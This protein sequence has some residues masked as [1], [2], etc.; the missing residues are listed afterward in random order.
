MRGFGENPECPGSAARGTLGQLAA[1]GSG[2]PAEGTIP[3]S[4]GRLRVDDVPLAGSQ[5]ET[6][7]QYAELLAEFE[8]FREYLPDALLE[9]ELPSM[10]VTFMNSIAKSL[11]GYTVDDILAG[12]YGWQLLEPESLQRAIALADLSLDRQ[13]RQGRPYERRPGQYLDRYTVIRKDGTP[14]AVEAQ[15]AFIVDGRGVPAGARFLFRDISD[16]LARDQER[17]RLAAIVESA[18][19]AIVSR[20]LEGRILSWNRGAERLYG[21][22][23]AEMV[24]QTA[25]VLAPPGAEGE[26]REFA[27]RVRRGESVHVTTRRRRRDGTVFDVEL[28]LFPVRDEQGRVTAMAGIARD[29]SERLRMTQELERTNR[30]LAALTRAQRDFI[31]G[32]DPERVF[33]ALLELLVELTGSE[34]GFIGEVEQGPGGEPQ[35]VPR[36]FVHPPTGEFEAFR[37]AAMPGEGRFANLATL[38]G[39]T[40]RTGEPVIAN[41][42]AADPRAGGIP[43]GHPELRS[44]LGIPIESRG[45]LV[46]LVGLANR[47]GGY[48]EELVAFVQP[49]LTTCA[50]VIE[51]LRAEQRRAEAERQLALALDGS[52][53]TLWDWDIPARRLRVVAGDAG[54]L[55]P[56]DT[57]EAAWLERV[58]PD[59][60]AGLVAAFRAHQRGETEVL[61]SEHRYRTPGGEWRWVLVRG[62]ATE[63][64]QCGQAVRASGSLLDVTRR[65]EAELERERLELL[66][67]QAQKLESL[68]VLAGGI[69]HDFNNLLTA[70]LGNLYLLR[71]ALPGDPALRELVDDAS[72]AAERGASLVRRLLTFGRP[73]IDQAE[74]VDLDAVIA[75]AVALARPM[76]EP[77][78]R[79]V[80]RGARERGRVLGSATALEQVLVNLFVN[81]RDAMPG[82]G[83]ITVTRSTT[84]LGA[85]RRWAPPE[86]PRG[87][88]HVVA[89]RDTGTGIPPEILEKIFDPFFTTKPVG[90][91]SGLG[92]PMALAIARAHG[93]WLSAESSPGRGSTF[94]L[95]LP[96]LQD[97]E[98]G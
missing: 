10:R 62:R 19:D 96:V 44:Y 1:P 35:M 30:L 89:V 78:V 59:D 52:E 60:R 80:V 41:D 64:D 58:H 87:R 74:A 8:Q 70:V 26:V 17:T 61:E 68:G 7:R 5:L 24:G 25:D 13:V 29:I 4:P 36:A 66:V 72:H 16:R 53:V 65:K 40:L 83:T 45:A 15:G 76:V 39:H 88:Y 31:R 73:D 97:G 86:L 6:A 81:A 37:A 2:A 27:E 54:G 21:Y 63:R 48:T 42:P 71:Q 56:E 23:A 92:L 43:P 33:G 57:T 11:L 84:E 98:T 34:V 55:A 18:E 12:V 9:V 91:G 82:G 93:G 90:R 77:T 67:R 47:P 75:D 51:A 20:D 79:L 85:R 95:L 3:G 32:G 69:A 14:V 49:V 28:S 22:T 38:F 46:G 94:R 50:T